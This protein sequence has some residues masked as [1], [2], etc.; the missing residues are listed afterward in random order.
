L[1]SLCSVVYIGCDLDDD[2][3]SRRT[4]DPSLFSAWRIDSIRHS[5]GGYFQVWKMLYYDSTHIILGGRSSDERESLWEFR[6]DVF[7]KLKFYG[8]TIS[9][10]FAPDGFY[11]ANMSSWGIVNQFIG[12]QTI[13][14]RMNPRTNMMSAIYQDSKNEY[15]LGFLREGIY[16]FDGSSFSADTVHVRLK[17]ADDR[18]FYINDFSRYESTRYAV[19]TYLIRDGAAE[20]AYLL[21]EVSPKRWNYIDSCFIANISE[22]DSVRF[23]NRRLYVSSDG[24]LFSV[25]TGGAFRYKK[26]HAWECIAKMDACYCIGG[27]SSTDM[28]LGSN[29]GRFFYYD[30]TTSKE[31]DW[32]KGSR[33]VVYSDIKVLE[34]KVFI[35]GTD[36]EI[37]VAFL[38]R[39]ERA[40]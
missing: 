38:I 5:A 3:V 35:T 13:E 23:G 20:W 24:V 1:F 6:D 2:P 4:F 10:S 27:T 31:L 25:G 8:S 36:N 11:V 14:Y 16:R 33:R 7:R 28:F 40:K 19:A 30:G 29:D 34:D 26:T 18:M 9:L 32:P 22:P 15:L 12:N 37:D 39:A 17:G 21:M